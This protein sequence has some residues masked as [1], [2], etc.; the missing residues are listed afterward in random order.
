VKEETAC[1][2]VPVL[3]NDHVMG[4]RMLGINEF[5]YSC[6]FRKIS[7]GIFCQPLGTPGTAVISAHH[8]LALTRFLAVGT[9]VNEYAGTSI[10]D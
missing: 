4:D 2:D 9:G 8:Y 5:G 10:S 3:N 6:F 1:D 7:K